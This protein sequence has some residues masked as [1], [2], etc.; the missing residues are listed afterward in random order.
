MPGICP[1]H[2]S[3]PRH[4]PEGLD[5][6]LDTDGVLLPT[7]VYTIRFISPHTVVPGTPGCFAVLL[8]TS[9]PQN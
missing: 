8:A 6:L 4:L 1:A 3:R 2:L 7:A 5:Q 9:Y